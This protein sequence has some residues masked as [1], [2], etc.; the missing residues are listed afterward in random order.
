MEDHNKAGGEVHGLV[1]FKEHMG[2]NAVHC[3]KETVKQ[4]AVI[5]EKAPEVFVNGEHAVPVG[6][7]HQLKGHI[8]SPFHGV[9]ITA[10]GAEAAFAAE[11]DEFQLT[12]VR[13]AIHGAAKGR[14]A[15]VYHLIDIIH[16]GFSGMEG[17]FNFFVMV[18]KNFL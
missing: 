11:R 9:F 14:V 8:C 4:G 16:L 17:I 3:M 13:A 1:L 10:C 12:A 6:Y 18:G 2:D 15:A 7:I 5:Q